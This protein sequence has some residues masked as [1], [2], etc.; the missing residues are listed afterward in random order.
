MLSSPRD[1][2]DTAVIVVHSHPS[3]LRENTS[4][5]FVIV[6]L[7]A[8]FPTIVSIPEE[9]PRYGSPG[10]VAGEQARERAMPEGGSIINVGSIHSETTQVG[11]FPYNAAKAGVNGMTRAMALELAPEI[12]VNGG[13]TA[14]FQDDLLG[15]YAPE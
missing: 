9:G 1:N 5:V 3:V 4:P 13:R 15:E 12:R 7:P 2:S 10:T 8:T 6:E 11:L 14:V